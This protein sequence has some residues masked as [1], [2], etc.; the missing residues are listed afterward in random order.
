MTP[1]EREVFEAVAEALSFEDPPADL[2]A[3]ANLF[4]T[5]GLDSIDALEIVLAVRKKY[6]V[7][8][9]PE[10]ESNKA[11]LSTVGS[12]AAFIEQHRPASA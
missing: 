3:D 5:F 10:E 7:H 4:E 12:L 11:V 8:F 1:F 9:S 2:S 6:G